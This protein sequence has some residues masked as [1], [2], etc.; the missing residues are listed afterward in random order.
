MKPEAFLRAQFKQQLASNKKLA[1]QT[2]TFKRQVEE[3]CITMWK[4]VYHRGDEAIR[5]GLDYAKLSMNKK[6]K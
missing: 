5:Q 1:A 4:Q 6:R 3:H 2:S